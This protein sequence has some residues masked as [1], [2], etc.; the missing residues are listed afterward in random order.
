LLWYIYIIQLPNNPKMSQNTPVNTN[1]DAPVTIAY[2]ET[3]NP[4]KTLVGNYSQ[5]VLDVFK[6]NN[7]PPVIRPSTAPPSG[8]S[9]CYRCPIFP[10]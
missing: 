4:D 7:K 1:T 9:D 2:T 8:R 6:K 5:R 10:F 3:Y